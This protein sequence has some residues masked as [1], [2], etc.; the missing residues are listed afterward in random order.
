MDWNYMRKGRKK[1]EAL[2]GPGA[3]N[4]LVQNHLNDGLYRGLYDF[5]TP[6]AA[7]A[8]GPHVSEPLNGASCNGWGW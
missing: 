7:H 8:A 6:R 3:V 1:K 5:L 4:V 2:D